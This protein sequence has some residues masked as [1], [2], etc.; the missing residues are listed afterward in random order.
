MLT[1][2]RAVV[3]LVA[4]AVILAALLFALANRGEQRKP[5]ITYAFDSLYEDRRAESYVD[6]AILLRQEKIERRY[7]PLES[8][9]GRQSTD[10]VLDPLPPLIA[11]KLLCTVMSETRELYSKFKVTRVYR[12]EATT[13][14]NSR[15]GELS[16][17]VQ[18]PSTGAPK[19]IP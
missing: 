1:T 6:E 13:E 18:G 19:M 7:T 5:T 4:L 11:H 16:I 17:A 15:T 14:V 10:C 12:W 8:E 9:P 2:R 3:F